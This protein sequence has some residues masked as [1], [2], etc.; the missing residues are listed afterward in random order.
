MRKI[1]AF[2][3]FFLAFFCASATTENERLFIK[4]DIESKIKAVE[5]ASGESAVFLSERG[6]DFVSEYVSVLGQDEELSALAAASI[7][8]F[9]K[10]VPTMSVYCEELYR[11]VRKT[12]EIFMEFDSGAVR[13]AA[14]D[15][16]ARYGAPGDSDIVRLLDSFLSDSFRRND[17]A[18]PVIQKALSVAGVVGGSSTLSVIFSIWL[19]K[20]WPEYKNEIDSSLI[21]LSS[22]SI[23]DVIKIFSVSKTTDIYDFLLLTKNTPAVS[24]VFLCQVAE[25]ALSMTINKAGATQ[26][27]DWEA[28]VLLQLTAV[29][30]LAEKQW[31]H[32]S[33]VVSANLILSKKE[34]D[35]ALMSEGQF[36]ETIGLSVQ[37]PS[38]DKAKF[39]S[40][41]LAECNGKMEKNETP[42]KSVVIALI[43]ALGVLGDKTAF[44][45][46]LY[47]TYMGYPD[48]VI[49]AARASLAALRW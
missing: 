49:Q 7:H 28:S 12:A 6:I 25:N 18:S 40:D 43:S 1:V 24:D 16:L 32:A 47:V 45:N 9:C 44:D 15:C 41:C 34:Y 22:H 26:D 2:F 4:G 19:S 48:D 33:A 29:R 11:F 37:L 46:L 13:I 10:A 3:L 17:G 38:A 27:Y 36:V 39:L 5:A 20:K 14:L 31:S 23:S 8:A 30:I 21:M 42:P 35:D